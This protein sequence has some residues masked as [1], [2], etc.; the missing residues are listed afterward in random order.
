MEIGLVKTMQN[1]LK[2]SIGFSLIALM[3]ATQNIIQAVLASVTIGFIILNVLAIVAYM[4]WPLGSSESVGVVVCVGFAVD[5]VVHLAAHYIH[6]KAKDRNG[7]VRESLRELGPS[8]LSGSVTTI[9]ASCCLFLGLLTMF[10]KFGI[11]VIATIIFSIFYSLGFFAALCH[12]IGPLGNFG[13]LNY[14]YIVI[15]EKILKLLKKP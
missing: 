8:I 12:V 1:G 11:L 5:Y 9:G 10:F 4:D 13:N 14:I 7:R 3:L 2:L 15:K 6:S